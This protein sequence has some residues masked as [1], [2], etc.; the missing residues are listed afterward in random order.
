MP[1]VRRDD[2]PWSCTL[3]AMNAQRRRDEREAKRR[4]R[5]PVDCDPPPAGWAEDDRREPRHG[6][7]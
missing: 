4:A 7:V 5:R 3:E 1:R 2:R 6:R